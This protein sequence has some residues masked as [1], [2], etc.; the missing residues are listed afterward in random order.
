MVS[1]YPMFRI[2]T[3]GDAFLFPNLAM[4]CVGSIHVVK[5]NMS[6]ERRTR[7]TRGDVPRGARV[8]I[9]ILMVVDDGRDEGAERGETRD[10]R[11]VVDENNVLYAPT[12][13]RVGCEQVGVGDGKGREDS[14]DLGPELQVR[15]GD[16]HHG[17]PPRRN[18]IH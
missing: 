9:L 13:Q 14:H 1:T 15:V 16:G 6:D 3:L 5:Q 4:S 10:E 17:C 7:T 8:P 2:S 12:V 11:I 18:G